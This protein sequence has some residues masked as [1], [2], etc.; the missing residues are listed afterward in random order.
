MAKESPRD[1]YVSL[2]GLAV[3]Q[4]TVHFYRSRLSL[5]TGGRN[6]TAQPLILSPSSYNLP[7]SPIEMHNLF[8]QWTSVQRKP[9]IFTLSTYTSPYVKTIV[10]CKRYLSTSEMSSLFKF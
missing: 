4:S 7:N 2:D 3:V 9:F 1:Q 10:H 5:S 8:K 6:H